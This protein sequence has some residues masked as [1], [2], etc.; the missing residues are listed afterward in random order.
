MSDSAQKIMDLYEEEYPIQRE[1]VTDQ[2]LLNRLW[3][4]TGITRSAARVYVSCLLDSGNPLEY[5]LERMSPGFF[6]IPINEFKQ[7][8]PRLAADLKRLPK[9]QLQVV[10]DEILEEKPQGIVDVV[11]RK[12]SY[13]LQKVQKKM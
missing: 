8:C 6:T 1:P 13:L 11:R 3:A 4:L 5:P 7:K 12:T 10:L 9:E 2:D